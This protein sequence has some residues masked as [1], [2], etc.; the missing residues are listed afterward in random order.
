VNGAE[1]AFTNFAQTVR[2]DEPFI[3][4]LDY[5]FLSDKVKPTSVLQ[6]PARGMVLFP[7]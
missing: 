3:D 6:L 1:P 5:F 2:D 4:T 7:L